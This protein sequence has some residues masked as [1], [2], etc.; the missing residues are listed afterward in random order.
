MQKNKVYC[1]LTIEDFADMFGTT[2]DDF[3]D[4]CKELIEQSDFRYQKI[5]DIE[6]D[7]I[8]LDVIKQLDS[9][10]LPVSGQDRRL[11]WERGWSEN[12]DNFIRSDYNIS[13]L[14]PKYFH[15]HRPVRI[16]RKYVKPCDEAFELNFIQVLRTWLAIKYLSDFDNIYEF[17][18]GTDYHLVALSRLFPDKKIHGLDWVDVSRTTVNL[19]A[20]KYGL[21]LKGHLF[22]FYEPDENLEFNK[23][24]AVLTLAAL[25][26]LGNQHEKFLKFL[27]EK[28]PGLC[29]NIECIGELYN[30]DNLLDYLAMRYEQKRGYLDGYL[31]RL[32]NLEAKKNIEIQK[33]KRTFFGNAYHEQYAIVVWKP[34]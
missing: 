2:L 9:D 30:P 33:V 29:I 13:E 3:S 32:Q 24:S 31:T 27:L 1:K 20:K 26:Q 4:I 34:K 23:N 12:L 22:N 19:I 18:C 25:E 8:I 21:N 14:V 16:S 10:D 6:R 28:K 5:T 11:D 7:D 17:G 15:P